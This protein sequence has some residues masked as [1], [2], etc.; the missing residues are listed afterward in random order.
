MGT[1]GQALRKVLFLCRANRFRSPLAAACF[2]RW[3][4]EHCPRSPWVALSA[5]TWTQEG[6]PAARLARAWAAEHDLDLSAHRTRQ[7]SAEVLREAER[8]IVME[9]SH[10]EALEAEFPWLREKGVFLLTE[11]AGEPPADMPDPEG[12]EE[13]WVYNSVAQEVCDLAREIARRWCASPPEEML[14][15]G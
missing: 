15:A 14:Y 6:L 4:Q 12:Q 10:R 5:G 3:M 7:V 13:A 9:E 8:V 11:A 2:N 1:P